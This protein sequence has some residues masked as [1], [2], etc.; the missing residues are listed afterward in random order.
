MNEQKMF[1][2]LA[3]ENVKRKEWE[4]PASFGISLSH[5]RL[6]HTKHFQKRSLPFAVHTVSSKSTLKPHCHYVQ[7]YFLEYFMEQECNVKVKM[8]SK[9]LTVMAS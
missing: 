7:M 6:S 5:S 4:C 8:Y 1:T 2:A 9:V 3:T